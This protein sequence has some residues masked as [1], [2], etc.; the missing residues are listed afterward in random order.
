MTNDAGCRDAVARH[1]IAA[2]LLH[3]GHLRLRKFSVAPFVAGVDDLD[4]DR[5]PIEIRLALPARHAGM[6][7]APLFRDQAP[8]S[9]VFLDDVMCADPRLGIAQALDGGFGALHTGVMQHQHIDRTDIGRLAA[10]GVVG[11][12][13][14][15]DLQAGHAAPIVPLRS[16]RRIGIATLLTATHATV[17]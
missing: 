6:E 2:Q 15:P 8:E 9:A 5:D 12:E 13:P 17:P 7:G 3:N 11:R 14:F 4:T 10:A 16:P 1:Q